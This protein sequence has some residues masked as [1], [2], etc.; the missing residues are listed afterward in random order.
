VNEKFIGSVNDQFI[1]QLRRACGPKGVL[2]DPLELLTYEC[3]GLPHLHQTPAVVVLPSSADQVQAIVRLCHQHEIPFV[4]RGHGSGLSGGA[5]PIPGGVVIGLSR[6]NR[7]LDV[8]IPNRRVTVEPGVTNLEITRQVA[9]HGFYYAPDPS[10]QQVCSIGG[11]VAENSG[12]AHCLK[13]GFTVHHV[14]GIEAVLPNGDLVRLDSGIADAPGPDLVGVLIGSEGTLAVVTK[15]IVRILRRPESVQT[16]LAAYD[17]ISAAGLAVSEII[18]AGIIP[19]AVEIMDSLSIEAVEAAVHPNFPPADSIL[20]VELDGPVAEVREQF[21]EVEAICRH[22]GA[23]TVEVAQD[24]AHRARIWKG[25]K[26]AFASMGRV[27][28]NYYVQDGVVPR[29]KLPE[30]L[31]RIRH[32]EARCG[33][34]I[35]NVFHAG[36]GNLHPLICYDEK[37]PGQSALAAEVGAEILSYCVEAGGSIT[38][39][40]GVGAD[41]A[42]YMPRMFSADDIDVMQLV[43]RAFDPKGICNPGKVFPAPRLCGEVPGPYRPHPIEKAGLGERF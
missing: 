21:V 39:E 16:L 9:S 42:E 3:D 37:I 19:A 34:R 38:G 33:L 26:G 17:S 13:Y 22:A 7:V 25:R 2:T 41:K 4:A 35:G 28:P 23:T 40:H 1:D 6:L 11:N 10:S 36:D 8:D 43:R 20:I 29:T 27:T 18:A 30:V 15:V 24:E 32:L 12:G 5:L 14:L 31:E